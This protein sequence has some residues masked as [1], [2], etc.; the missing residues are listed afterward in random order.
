MIIK[1]LEGESEEEISQNV[2]ENAQKFIKQ[3]I[4]PLKEY[5]ENNIKPDMMSIFQKA[6]D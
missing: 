1:D 6:P 5:V 3:K 4:P 2:G